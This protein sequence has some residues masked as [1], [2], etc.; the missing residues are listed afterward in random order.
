MSV[1]CTG[2]YAATAGEDKVIGIWDMA[3]CQCI[4]KESSIAIIT[5]LCWHPKENE[6]ILGLDSGEVGR[7]QK[8]IPADML[9]PAEEMDKEKM[10]ES[11]G[12]FLNKPIICFSCS[13]PHSTDFGEKKK[14]IRHQISSRGNQHMEGMLGLPFSQEDT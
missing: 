11:E 12:R 6:I 13:Y 1:G 3:K 2:L 4:R 14:L 9:G 5:D 10:A 8:V 7:W